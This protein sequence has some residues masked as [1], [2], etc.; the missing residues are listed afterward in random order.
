MNE[1]YTIVERII[2]DHFSKD[3]EDRLRK[4]LSARGS[5][6]PQPMSEERR[7][8]EHYKFLILNSRNKKNR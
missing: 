6:A 7:G 1:Y 2:E 4:K 5:K 3:D 8:I